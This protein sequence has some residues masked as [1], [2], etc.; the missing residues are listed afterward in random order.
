MKLNKLFQHFYYYIETYAK[1]KL[2]KGI[3]N[4]VLNGEYI[5]LKKIIDNVK[6]PNIIDVGSNVG[7]Y[8]KKAINYAS[9]GILKECFFA[10]EDINPICAFV[11]C[12]LEGSEDF[13]PVKCS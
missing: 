4:P 6:S 12:S 3:M 10:G 5:L 8:T 11:D 13:C 7:A 9:E 2:G 1:N